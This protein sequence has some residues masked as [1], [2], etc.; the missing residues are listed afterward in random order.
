MSV[1]MDEDSLI[2]R[3]T[4]AMLESTGWYSSVPTASAREL[5]WGR[6]KGCDF[7]KNP[8]NPAWDGF[9]KSD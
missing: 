9:C 5:S 4:Y 8:C 7:V 6:S 1:E 2:S 3:F